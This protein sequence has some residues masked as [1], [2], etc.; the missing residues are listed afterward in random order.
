MAREYQKAN[1]ARQ[2]LRHLAYFG[3]AVCLLMAGG[4][5]AAET[6]S[7]AQLSRATAQASVTIERPAI[8]RTAALQD[9]GGWTSENGAT[10]VAPIGTSQRNCDGTEGGCQLVIYDMP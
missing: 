1:E 6:R 7:G 8:I 2:S 4:A 5:A 10:R 3:A 9:Q